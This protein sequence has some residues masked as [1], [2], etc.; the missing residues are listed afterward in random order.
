MKVQEL[1]DKLKLLPAT[2]EVEV[3]VVEERYYADC[4]I[5]RLE[6]IEKGEKYP[7]GEDHDP[8]LEKQTVFIIVNE[9]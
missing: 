6:L 4:P 8:N 1:I 3:F 2:A 7:Y 5:N 9:E